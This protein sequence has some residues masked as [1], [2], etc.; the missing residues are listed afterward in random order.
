[1]GVRA[2]VCRLQAV[3]PWFLH[4]ELDI[5][6]TLTLRDLR[7]WTLRQKAS[8]AS[9]V[10]GVSYNGRTERSTEGGLAYTRG[11]LLHP[12]HRMERRKQGGKPIVK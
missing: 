12:G 3:D 1:M 5:R 2:D 11:D 8:E 6:L 7:A 9:T 10:L 4:G